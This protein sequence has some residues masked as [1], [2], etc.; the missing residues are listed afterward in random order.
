MHWKVSPPKPRLPVLQ[1][2]IKGYVSA[3]HRW[4][5]CT[6]YSMITLVDL[7]L[8]QV[9]HLQIV[10]IVCMFSQSVIGCGHCKN[11]KPAYSEAA[12]KLKEIQVSWFKYVTCCKQ[13]LI[14]S[15]LWAMAYTLF[16][17]HES[18]LS[19]AYTKGVLNSNIINM[20]WSFWFNLEMGSW[21]S[22]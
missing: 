15:V 18:W 4:G 21:V 2:R 6:F 19:L 5:T 8:V 12:T 3:L 13:L 1:N 9:P 14:I 20:L 11:M 22:S 10:N 17:S 7:H 16:M